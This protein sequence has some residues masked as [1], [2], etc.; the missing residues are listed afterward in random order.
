M[1]CERKKYTHREGGKMKIYCGEG[2]RG[3][4]GRGGALYPKPSSSD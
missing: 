3:E 4:G 1:C 2:E